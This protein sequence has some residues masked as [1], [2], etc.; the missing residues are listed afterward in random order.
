M[1]WYE[2]ITINI[3]NN[4]DPLVDN[5]TESTVEKIKSLEEYKNI[6]HICTKTSI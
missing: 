4:G 6:F 5:P 3:N 2:N 1:V